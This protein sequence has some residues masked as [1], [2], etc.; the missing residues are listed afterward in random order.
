MLGSDRPVDSDMDSTSYRADGDFERFYRAEIG[1][2]VRFFRRRFGDG[3]E[4]Q[5]LAQET[6]LR[7]VNHAPAGQLVSPQA[8][9][10][11]IATN[12]ALDRAKSASHRLAQLTSPLIEG[13]DQPVGI[14]QHQ[15]VESREELAQ[16]E[17]ILSKLKP[18]TLE[19]FLL[20]RVDRLSYSQIAVHLGTTI[21]N[22]KWHMSA[23]IR[24]V[25]RHRG[26]R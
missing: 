6:M 25:A 2:L 19:I 11:H 4:A 17:A 8:Y 26:D 18:R 22:V 24:H 3:S 14:D 23:A 7:F 16:W 10:R 9:L 15:I 5:D 21:F 12:L 13:L 20:S 1:W